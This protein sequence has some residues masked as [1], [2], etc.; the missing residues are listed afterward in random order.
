MSGAHREKAAER[1]WKHR[2]AQT[3][4]DYF[5]KKGLDRAEALDDAYAH[6]DAQFLVR[7]LRSPEDEARCAL[8]W[9]TAHTGDAVA[10]HDRTRHETNANDD[11]HRTTN[12]SGGAQH[13][14]G[15]SDAD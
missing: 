11:T 15:A 12:G 13:R 5:C 4:F 9:I 3:L 8:T 1:I 14:D 7:G 6:A 2:F 10:I